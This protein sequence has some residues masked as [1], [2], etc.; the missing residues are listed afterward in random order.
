MK[1]VR[2]YFE[3]SG[4]ISGT[5]YVLRNLVAS[6]GGFIGGFM[7]GMGIGASLPVITVLGVLVLIPVFWFNA[8]NIY[9]RSNALFPKYAVAI[10]I[11][12]FLLQI[13]SEVNQLFSIPLLITGLVLVFKNS[14]IEEHN[15]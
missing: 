15:G 7:T 13:F 5:N 3:F 11:C 8:T 12:M 6:L 9:K 14:N 1:N 2:K 10:T 4:T